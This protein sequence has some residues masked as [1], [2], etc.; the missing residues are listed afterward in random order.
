[1]GRKNIL[2]GWEALSDGDM[3]L[4]QV[5]GE[6]TSVSGFDTITYLA[7]WTGGNTNNGE[8]EIET[9]MDEG[10]TW[11]TL[12]FGAQIKVDGASD[13]ARMVITEIGFG[14]I[15]PKF[16]KIDALSSGLITIKIFGTNKGC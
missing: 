14:L 7:T 11:H 16:K 4:A 1:M 15:R 10:K 3:S 13:F 6:P 9:S 8:I 12:D 5:T 2:F